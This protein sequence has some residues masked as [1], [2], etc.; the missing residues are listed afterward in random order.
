MPFE[1]GVRFYTKA[2]GMIE[3]SFPENKTVCQYCPF[4]FGDRTERARCAYTHEFILYPKVQVG[5]DCPLEIVEVDN[6]A[7][8]AHTDE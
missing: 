6:V 8:N 1:K 5:H 2:V 3:V 7:R 4:C